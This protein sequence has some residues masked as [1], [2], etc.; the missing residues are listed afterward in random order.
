M[1][2][3]RNSQYYFEWVQF[4]ELFSKCVTFNQGNFNLFYLLRFRTTDTFSYCHF[5]FLNDSYTSLG[6]QL[7]LADHAFLCLE[8]GL[9]TRILMDSIFDLEYQERNLLNYM[10]TLLWKFVHLAGLSKQHCHHLLVEIFVG[11][12][13]HFFYFN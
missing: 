9:C 11:F 12:V 13:I 3:P 2:L 7:D 6:Y 1:W 4:I 10:A 5:R 8:F